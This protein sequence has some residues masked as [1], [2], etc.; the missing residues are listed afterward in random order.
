[1]NLYCVNLQD[2]ETTLYKPLQDTKECVLDF[3][4]PDDD[5]DEEISEVDDDEDEDEEEEEEEG[6]KFIA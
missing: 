3:I 5:E 1:M 2:D 6:Y 4:D